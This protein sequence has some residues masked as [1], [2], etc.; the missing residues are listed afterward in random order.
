VRFWNNAWIQYEYFVLHWVGNLYGYLLASAQNQSCST[1][2]FA[3]F[4]QS[5]QH[6]NDVYVKTFQKPIDELNKM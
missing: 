6:N 4:T 1:E 3:L 5:L 2:R